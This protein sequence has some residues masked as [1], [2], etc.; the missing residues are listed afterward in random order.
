ML[1]RVV[2][3]AQPADLEALVELVEVL[4]EQEMEFNPD[5][6]T[7]RRGLHAPVADPGHGR[8]LVAELEGRMVGMVSIQ[9][10]VSTALGAPAAILED[11]I[12]DPQCRGAGIGSTLLASAIEQAEALGCRR[13]TLLV[14]ADNADAQRLY[15]R[16]GFLPSTMVPMRR[17]L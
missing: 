12:V 10:T 15:E 2:R 13:I 16:H 7:Q 8:V 6:P 4:C 3:L 9:L 1:T 5:A 14:D 17:F 11:L